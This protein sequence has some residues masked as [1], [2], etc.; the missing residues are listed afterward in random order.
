MGSDPVSFFANIFLFLYE[1]KW[2]KSVQNTNCSITRKFS[3][4]FRF[5]DDLIAK[6]DGNEFENHY[7]NIYSPEQNLKKEKKDFTHRD[8]TSRPYLFINEGQ[9]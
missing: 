6:H 3:N 1:S 4:I 7:N 8:Y 9:N 2:C 5:I